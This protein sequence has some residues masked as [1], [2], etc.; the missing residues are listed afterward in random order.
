[1][2]VVFSAWSGGEGDSATLGQSALGKGTAPR[3]R[4]TEE[5]ARLY[6]MKPVRSMAMKHTVTG[7]HCFAILHLNEG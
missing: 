7:A 5:R 3:R 6:L 4:L 2:G 1:M